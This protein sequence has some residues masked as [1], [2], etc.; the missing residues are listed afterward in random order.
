MKALACSLS[1]LVSALYLHA[2]IIAQWNFNSVP[3]D[4]D[5]T[6]GSTVPSI[7][8]GIASLLNGV[9][10]TFSDGSTNDPATTTDDTGWSTTH[11]PAQGTSNKTAGV[12]FN[13]ST[14]GYSNIVI[15]WDQRTT[16]SASKYFRLQYSTDGSTFSDYSN[17]I[18]AQVAAPGA[19]YYEA[20]T[21]SLA[22]ITAVNDNPNFAFRIVSEWESSAAGTS[23]NGYV[24]LGSSYSASQGTVRF[25]FVTISGMPLPGANTAPYISSID[26]SIIRVNHSTGPIPF[27]VLDAED[28]ASNLV[29]YATSSD[30]AVISPGNVTFG[31]SGSAR[32]VNVSAGPQ[33]GSSLVSVWVIDTGGKSNSATFAV[34]VLPAN[35]A[36]MISVI[37]A[38]N[39]LVNTPISPLA[40]TV[41]DAETSASSLTVTGVSANPALVPDSSIVFGGSA[42]NR[43]VAVTPA[44]GRVGVAPITVTVSDGTN[45]AVSTFGVMVRPAMN[46]LVYEPFDYT[47]GS[48]ITNSGFLW[49]NH[50]GTF[51]E[52][53]VTGG[54]LEVSGAQTEDVAVSLAG[55]PYAK[56]LGT[57][58]YTCFKVNFQALPKNTP[59]YFAALISGSSQIARIYAG[60]ATNAPAGTFHLAVANGSST[61]TP[62]VAD[63]NTNATYTIVTRY[64]IDTATTTLWVDPSAESDPGVT[65]S[66]PVTPASVSSFEFREGSGL[67]AT[68]LVD[69]L[70]IGLS[71]TSVTATNAV[72]PSPIPLVLN[73]LG[74][75]VVLTWTNPAFALQAAPSIT[76]AFTNI[77]SAS[78]PYTNPIS[79]SA[80]FFRLK[81]N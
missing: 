34:T 5:K 60:S 80:K 40:F 22:A 13:V 53:Q 69:D 21:N 45:V 44:A 50:T 9:T 63:L 65:A 14:V 24:T 56:N 8:N 4:S 32:T 58:L 23:S 3:A 33:D 64:N 39:T 48:V 17:P 43:T 35:T 73:H 31:G 27:T 74:N 57:V 18:I 77:P 19:T 42:S 11:Y 16:A 59:D 66:D 29:L 1:L 71:F 15:R 41:G 79:G 46:V 12:Q 38:T 61:N 7:G 28:A 55:A 52:C 2:D 75:N 47:D 49:N 30:P 20:E 25:D 36:P 68:I 72:A 62:W 70:R 10:A 78:S 76:A 51:G 37:P 54:Q 6:S 67:G 81:W 26:D